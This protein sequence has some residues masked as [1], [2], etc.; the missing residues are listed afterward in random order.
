MT[1][2]GQYWAVGQSA[3]SPLALTTSELAGYLVSDWVSNLPS[4]TATDLMGWPQYLL[5]VT[6][7]TTELC[8]VPELRNC[9][10]QW[11]GFVSWMLGVASARKILDEERYQWI[12]PVS[13]FYPN[14]VVPVTTHGWHPSYPPSRLRIAADP[15]NTSNLLPD[16]VALR[17]AI[18]GGSFN[19]AL[20]EAKGIDRSLSSMTTALR[21][22]SDQ[23]RNAKVSLVAPKSNATTPVHISRHLVIATRVS[24]NASRDTTRRLQIRAWNS[25]EAVSNKDTNTAELEVIAAHLHGLCQNLGLFRNADAIARAARLRNGSTRTINDDLME[26]LR[27]DAAEELHSRMVVST[28]RLDYQD[29]RPPR[30]V[31]L[32]ER[33]DRRGVSNAIVTVEAATLDLLELVQRTY[34]VDS[35]DTARVQGLSRELTDWY[36]KRSLDRR[37]NDSIQRDGVTVSMLT[38]DV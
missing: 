6:K 23:V 21:P 27:D 36:S 2:V 8:L 14:K 31:T 18:S 12:A 28:S 35:I 1:T 15:K 20:V 16:Y 25:E 38:T 10:R 32:P 29:Q 26:I 9:E 33:R 17:P 24:P 34:S 7:S 5:T 22:W 13:A 11:K 3:S 4:V 37:A 30:R 19:W